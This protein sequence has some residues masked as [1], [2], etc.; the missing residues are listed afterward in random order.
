MTAND[1]QQ[2][3]VTS[4]LLQIY[5][6]INYKNQVLKTTT[7]RLLHAAHVKWPGMAAVHHTKEIISSCQIKHD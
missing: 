2:K 7:T 3:V 5:E 6:D 4:V 1:S